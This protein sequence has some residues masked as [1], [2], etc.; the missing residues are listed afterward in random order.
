ML[1]GAAT[2]NEVPPWAKRHVPK[3]WQLYIAVS[4][5]VGRQMAFSNHK[6]AQIEMATE[7]HISL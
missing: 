6:L 1:F 4:M 3:I 2:T 5:Q 7:V